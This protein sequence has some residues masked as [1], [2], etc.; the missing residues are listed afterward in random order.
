MSGFSFDNLNL[1]GVTVGG[2]S[3]RLKAGRFVC[4]IKSAVVIDT[5][6]KDGS[7]KLEL[8]LDD[9]AGSGAIKHNINVYLVGKPE[10]TEIGRKELKSVL[11]YGG[12]PNPDRPGDVSSM[13]GLKIGVVVKDAPYTD[14]L[15]GQPKNGSEVAFVTDPAEID[16]AN[17]APR[18][19]AAPA[20]T[21]IEDDIPF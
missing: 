12:H 9:V 4:E 7:K 17:Y 15:T 1:S 13:R 8:T 2:T 11:F 10:A 6:K 14:R 20:K 3:R 19:A 16:P 18:A 5:A 21:S